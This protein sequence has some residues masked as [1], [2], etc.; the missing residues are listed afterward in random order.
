M[1]IEPMESFANIQQSHPG[2][3]LDLQF[4]DTYWLHECMDT[5]TENKYHNYY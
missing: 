2:S 3:F 4:A 5:Y 1:F